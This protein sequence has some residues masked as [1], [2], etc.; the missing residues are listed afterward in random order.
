MGTWSPFASASGIPITDSEV[1]PEYRAA[2]LYDP[3]TIV[4][5]LTGA[6]EPLPSVPSLP[7][8]QHRPLLP[9]TAHVLQ[10]LTASEENVRNVEVARGTE[11]FA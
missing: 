9:L 5:T 1:E 4:G 7:N 6:V 8:P 11:E 2:K 10:E 3:A